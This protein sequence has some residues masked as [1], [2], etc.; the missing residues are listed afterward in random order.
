MTDELSVFWQNND[1]AAA[2]FYDLLARTQ[3]EAYDDEFLTQLA[4]YRTAGGDAVHADIFAAHYLLHEGDAE[5][6]VLCAERAYALRPVSPAVWTV[7][8]R[9]YTALHRYADALVI[10]GYLTQLCGVPLALNLPPAA[11]DETALARLSVA[12]SDPSHAPFAT[13]MSYERET[14]LSS[15]E[16]LFLSEFLPCPQQ[17][18]DP[19]YVGVYTEQGMQ[20]AHLWQMEMLRHT[21]GTSYFAGGDA[22]FD[23]LRGRKI[24]S[25]EELR[26]SPH[27]EIVL[28]L[29]GTTLPVLDV[30]EAQR[31]H[32][33]TETIDDHL[34]LNAGTTNFVR[35]DQETTLT[36]DADFIVGTPIRIGH[37]SMRRKIVLNILVDALPWDIIGTDFETYMPETAHFFARGTIFDQHFS[38]AEYTYPSFPTIETGMY[39]HRSGLFNNKLSMELRS[40]DVTLSERARAAGY[41][42]AELLGFGCGIYDGILRGFDRLI[43]SM[44]YVSASEGVEHTIHHLDA[45]RD[46]DHYL[47]IHTSDVH[48]WPPPLFQ[49]PTTVQAQ[50]PLR[51]RVTEADHPIASPYMQPSPVNHRIFWQSIRDTDRALGTLFSYLEEQYA[52]EDYIVNLYSDHGVSIF[53]TSQDIVGTGL[54]HAAWMMRGA[55]APEGVRTNEPTSAVDIYPALAHLLDF[56]VGSN[57][58]GILPKILGGT[59]RDITYSNSL[60]P[61][62]PYFLA[63]RSQTH[64]LRLETQETVG[65]DGTV[66]LAHANVAIYLRPHENEADYAVDSTELRTFFYPR[67]R[68]FL[69]GI[70]NNGEI[71]PLPKEP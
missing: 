49:I 41:A 53:S 23:L 47:L 67:V 30:R 28:P 4:A 44:Y 65:M 25:G 56:P 40:T 45:L 33:K 6:A 43:T 59:G 7:L 24:P 46:A 11:L 60:Y 21:A 31:I 18:V 1:T 37:S 29:I 64:T 27:G 57:V 54:T 35:L 9:A 69:R 58:D 22:T 70:G 55:G 15:E 42:T 48:P 17:G 38:A 8:V 50:L 61:G 68:E 71:F 13:R 63:A 2:L 20:G 39:P 62:K 34:W 32:V 36:S 14:G 51:E 12:L 5:N 52:P 3:R 16:S 66:D 10:H 26:L 19:Y